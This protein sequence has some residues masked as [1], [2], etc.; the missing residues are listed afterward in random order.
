MW[1][2]LVC[3]KGTDILEGPAAR[4]FT[5]RPEF[6]Y[7][8]RFLNVAAFYCNLFINIKRWNKLLLFGSNNEMLETK[9]VSI[10]VCL[11]IL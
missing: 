2:G 9:K 8:Y 6:M 3:Y 5:E 7:E 10:F 4:T 1:V 11:I